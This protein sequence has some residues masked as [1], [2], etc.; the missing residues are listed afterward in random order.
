MA[1]RAAPSPAP[2]LLAAGVVTAAVVWATVSGGGLGVLRTMM[3]EPLYLATLVDLY[4]ALALLAGWIWIRERSVVRL[5]LWSL[6]M[7]LTGAVAAGLY[8]AVAAR[9]ARGDL[10]T[11]MLGV[12]REAA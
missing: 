9:R 2:G 5:L 1:R 6:A 4:A 3:G 7:L 12:S 10:P 11:F 8:V